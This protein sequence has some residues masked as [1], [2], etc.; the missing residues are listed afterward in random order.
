[1]FNYSNRAIIHQKGLLRF[2]HPI[3]RK[4]RDTLEHLGPVPDTSRLIFITV[5]TV[6]FSFIAVRPLSFLLFIIIIIIIFV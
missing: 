5:L 6:R 4:Q 1:M 2:R 3:R